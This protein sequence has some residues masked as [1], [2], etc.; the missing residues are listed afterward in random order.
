[1][2]N[3]RKLDISEEYIRW[4][5]ENLLD[6]FP[7]SEKINN[8]LENNNI[9]NWAKDDILVKNM[10]ETN[11][12]NFVACQEIN[13][14]NID[15]VNPKFYRWFIYFDG[16]K[17]YIKRW[18]LKYIAGVPFRS[19]WFSAEEYYVIWKNNYW[20]LTNFINSCFLLK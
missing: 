11:L 20:D 17:Y 3:I 10:I 15:K 6:C 14:E 1:M 19:K 9:P 12:W 4:L 16:E 2:N 13:D 5:E 18:K 7:V 8:I